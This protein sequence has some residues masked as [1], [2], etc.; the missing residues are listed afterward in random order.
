MTGETLVLARQTLDIVPLVMRT[1][2][3]ELRRGGHSLPASHFRLMSMLSHCP[4]NLSELARRQGVSLP[5]MSD[6]ITLLVDRGLARREPDGRDRRVVNVELTE[7]G[8]RAL[9][10]TQSLVEQGLAERLAGLSPDQLAGLAAGLNVLRLV[11]ASA[12][13]PDQVKAKD[14]LDAAAR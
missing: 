2:A 14:D 11:T 4:C 13:S 7:A 6:S 8:R 12:G 1:I 5:T 3:V 10:E 9:D